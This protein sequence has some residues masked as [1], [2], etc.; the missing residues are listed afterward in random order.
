MFFFMSKLRAIGIILCFSISI[1]ACA[2]PRL[3]YIN[4]NDSCASIRE[5][6][7]VVLERQQEQI[8]TWAAR[9]AAI[10]AAGGAGVGNAVDGSLGGILAGLFI[11]FVAGAITGAAIGYYAD[12]EERAASTAALRNA[13][14]TDAATDRTESDRLIQAIVSLNKC[15]LN[16]VQAVAANYQRGRIM[17]DAA[18]DRL[19]LQKAAIE[20]DNELIA[21]VT[22]GLAKR[23]GIYVDAL[24]RSGVEDT[25]ALLT[26]AK[27]YEPRIRRAEFTVARAGEP[28]TANTTANLR[29]GPS[30]NTAVIGTV[31]AGS[32]V[33]VLRREGRWSYVISNDREGYVASRLLGD[34]PGGGVRPLAI[35]SRAR[36][37]P[38]NE[39]AG[40]AQRSVELDAAQK[41]HVASVRRSIQDTEALLL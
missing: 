28:I 4:P 13:V 17:R 35:E 39:V 16:A 24:G 1:T 41:E 3:T 21:K 20:A 8:Q 30:T 6:F 32:S 22:E 7:V 27:D 36:P 25:D 38:E 26:A 34:A 23:A 37:R 40:L 9:G 2:S 12:L 18:E 15:R 10:G 11:G 5:P 19:A 29:S 33:D 14:F 31:S